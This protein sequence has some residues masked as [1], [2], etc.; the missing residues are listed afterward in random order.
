VP[1]G[2]HVNEPYIVSD[3]PGAFFAFTSNVDAHHY[4]WFQACEIRECHGNVELYQ[5]A[6]S[7]RACRFASLVPS[8]QDGQDRLGICGDAVWR[9]P[10]DYHFHVD[11]ET[12]LAP[13]PNG[14]TQLTDGVVVNRENK[15]PQISLAASNKQASCQC[16][17]FGSDRAKEAA[18]VGQ[19]RGGGRPFA[20]RNMPDSAAIRNAACQKGFAGNH[21]ICPSCEGPARPAI[22]MFGDYGWNDVPSQRRRWCTWIETVGALAEEMARATSSLRIAI[23]EIGCGSRVPTVRKNSEQQL[24]ML[25]SRGGN[26]RLIRINPEMNDVLADLP[27]YQPMIPVM[28]IM[29]RGLDSLRKIDAAMNVE[30]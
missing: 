2:E 9:C 11:S 16:S 25:E 19:A 23:L 22:Q 8:G 13:A 7:R 3:H 5:C 24:R 10:P 4:D 6:A 15:Q 18:A 17:C 30:S 20:L 29:A 26:V 27:E 28:S 21:P 12:M 14:T 1:F